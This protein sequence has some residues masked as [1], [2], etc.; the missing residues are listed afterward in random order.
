M[1][2][3]DECLGA[4]PTGLAAPLVAQKLLGTTGEYVIIF[5]IL[6]QML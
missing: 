1:C 3:A 5:L 2:H 6:V 4:N